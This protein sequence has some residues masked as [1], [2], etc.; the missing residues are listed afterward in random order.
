MTARVS[1]IVPA[2]NEGPRIGAVL[3]VVAAHPM[4]DQ[5]I[6]VDD[7]STDDTADIIARQGNVTLVRLTPNVGKT[8]A[9]AAGIA[10]ATGEHL[11]LI[12]SDLTGLDVDDLT[13]LI[14]PVLEGRADMAIS[15]R[16][17]APRLW[18]RIGVDYISGERMLRRSLI[19]ERLDEVQDLPRFGFEVWLNGIFVEA[20]VGLAVV[21]WNSVDSP[22]KIRKHGL[23]AGMVADLRML[24]DLVR[25]AGPLRLVRQILRMR[26]MRI[27][28][29]DT[30]PDLHR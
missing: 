24:S 23:R 20:G 9:V 1:C 26:A 6:A 22:A 19:A 2:F 10:R 4:I 15:L 5:I 17:N 28:D 30:K 21:R 27:A 14:R 3:A 29:M 8:R 25:G 13:A 11:L 18:H 7:G 16:R 12:D